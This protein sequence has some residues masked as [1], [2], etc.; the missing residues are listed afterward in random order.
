MAELSP[1]TDIILGV[2]WFTRWNPVL[3]WHSFA[4]HLTADPRYTFQAQPRQRSAVYELQQSE[5]GGLS[6]VGVSA[7][8]TEGKGSPSVCSGGTCSGRAPVTHVNLRQLST[9]QFVREFS[10]VE[11]EEVFLF[12][13][14]RHDDLAGRVGVEGLPSHL[15][16]DIDPRVQALLSEYSDVFPERLPKGEPNH[17]FRHHI[18][19]LPGA[20]PYVR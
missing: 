14:Q 10:K 8:Q 4:V 5:C 6:T 19:L 7:V 16:K 15:P 11:P 9:K 3:D 12:F 20:Q 18:K 17:P 2:P 1:G 13:I